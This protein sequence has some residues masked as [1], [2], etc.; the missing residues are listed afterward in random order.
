M[1]IQGS[2]LVGTNPGWFH[3][4]MTAVVIGIII[5]IIAFKKKNKP[6]VIISLLIFI[7]IYGYTEMAAA[8]LT[9]GRTGLNISDTKTLTGVEIYTNYC[10]SCHGEN[11]KKSLG[12]AK[13][14]SISELSEE[15]RIKIITN[16]KN[17]MRGYKS[18]GQEKIKKVASYV[19]SLR[20]Y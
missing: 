19:K 12:G 6:L 9:K 8:G 13:D 4:K 15:E 20:Q 5:A 16:G 14:L 11:G 17:N 1:V 2:A 10:V 7:G 3:I 18:L